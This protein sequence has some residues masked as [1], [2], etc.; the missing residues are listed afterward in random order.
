[1]A[2]ETQGIHVFLEP[3]RIP[4]NIVVFHEK[5]RQSAGMGKMT[6]G[7]F[8]IGQSRVKNRSHL[9]RNIMAFLAES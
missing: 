9:I 4:F 7:A 3:L 5:L 1:M 8:T 6:I 2:L